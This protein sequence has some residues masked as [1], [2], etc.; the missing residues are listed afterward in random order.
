MASRPLG[1]GVLSSAPET[2][3]PPQPATQGVA[4]SKRKPRPPQAAQPK[5]PQAARP[6]YRVRV[7]TLVNKAY[8]ARRQYLAKTRTFDPYA[9]GQMAQL[10]SDVVRCLTIFVMVLVPFVR[11]VRPYCPP[12]SLGRRKQAA[13]ARLQ[14]VILHDAKVI[15]VFIIKGGLGKT[16]RSIFRARQFKHDRPDLNILVQDC[17]NGT[18][19]SRLVRTTLLSMIDAVVNVSRIRTPADLKRYCTRTPE[20]LHVMAYKRPGDLRH[21]RRISRDEIRQ[22]ITCERGVVDLLI[23]DLGPNEDER[24]RGALDETHQL[25][26]ITNPARDSLQKALDTFGWL[27]ENGYGELASHALIV[28]NWRMPWTNLDKIYRRFEEEFPEH[29]DHVK[30]TSMS[31]VIRLFLGWDV[32]LNRLSR[33]NTVRLMEDNAATAEA[34][35]DAFVDDPESQRSHIELE[36]TT[37]HSIGSRAPSEHVIQK[38]SS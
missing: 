3:D 31:F 9:V 6:S 25:E 22:L 20:G 35:A 33:R 34:L 18:L 27:I 37:P 19:I 30:I 15:S 13:L 10:R 16:T 8:A 36:L 14:R 38:G 1:A 32:V 4:A 29:T 17:D 7:I 28:V 11:R 21:T 12:G 23:N 26:I 2:T 5:S 24:T